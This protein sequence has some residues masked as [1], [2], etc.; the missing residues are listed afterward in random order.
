MLSQPPHVDFE[1][2]IGLQK[3]SSFILED[4]FSNDL[5]KGQFKFGSAEQDFVDVALPD[6][7]QPF[8]QEFWRGNLNSLMTTMKEPDGLRLIRNT[9]DFTNYGECNFTGVPFLPGGQS[10]IGNGTICPGAIHDHATSKVAHSRLH[11]SYGLKHVETS[12][13][14][15]DKFSGPVFTTSSSSGISASCGAVI[16]K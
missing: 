1:A 7:E 10:L 12:L 13:A 2:A 4:S 5:L 3:N 16:M 6:F 11:N 9:P 14:G 8:L 15:L